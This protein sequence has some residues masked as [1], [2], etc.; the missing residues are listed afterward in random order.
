MVEIVSAVLLQKVVLA[1]LETLLEQQVLGI[2]SETI[3]GIQ[4][5]F[6]KHPFFFSSKECD[7]IDLKLLLKMFAS[8][9]YNGD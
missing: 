3:S 1:N 2:L 4:I 5:L 6:S 9:S 7:L 8:F